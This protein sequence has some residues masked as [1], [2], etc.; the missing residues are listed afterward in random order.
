[1]SGTTELDSSAPH[2]FNA[3]RENLGM[4][5]MGVIILVVWL[6]FRVWL[7]PKPGTKPETKQP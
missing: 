4:A 2:A 5:A 1:M 3:T 6:L 7:K